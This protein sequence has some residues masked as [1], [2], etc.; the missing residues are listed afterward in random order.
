MCDWIEGR[1]KQRA[2]AEAKFPQ[3]E[4]QRGHAWSNVEKAIRDCAR[5]Y[6]ECKPIGSSNGGSTLV[7]TTLDGRNVTVARGKQGITATRGKSGTISFEFN[8]NTSGVIEIVHG[9]ASV[10]SEKAAELILDP[11]FFPEFAR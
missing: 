10:T 11:L 7:V 3:L 6:G 1:R 9:G 4:R 5:E 2:D 8:L